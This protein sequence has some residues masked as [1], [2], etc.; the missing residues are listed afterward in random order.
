M[1]ESDDTWVC[2]ECNSFRFSESFFDKSICVEM[3]S[4]NKN[5]NEQ[6]VFATGLWHPPHGCLTGPGLTDI[7]PL[8][9]IIIIIL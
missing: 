7:W 5:Q 1:C 8:I 6:C 4:D 9:I 3:D 2:N